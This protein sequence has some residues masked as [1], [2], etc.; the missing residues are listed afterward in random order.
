V[1]KMY[2]MVSSLDEEDLR[3]FE[4]EKDDVEKKKLNL[5]E[6][7]RRKDA[8][9]SSSRRAAGATANEERPS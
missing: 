6:T 3:R 2:G 8:S 5:Q 9:E 4:G 7:Q 1:R